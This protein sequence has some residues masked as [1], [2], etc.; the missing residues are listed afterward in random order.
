ML[1]VTVTNVLLQ[2]PDILTIPSAIFFLTIFFLVT[3]LFAI[4]YPYLLAAPIVFF[5]PFLVLAL[6]LVFC[7]LQGKPFLCLNPLYEPKSIK[8]LISIATFFLRS[9]STR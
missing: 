5:L 9:P 1:S 4:I 7:P 6:V 3:F 8:D 2:L